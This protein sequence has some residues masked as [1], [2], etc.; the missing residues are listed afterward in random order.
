MCETIVKSG[1]DGEETGFADKGGNAFLRLIKRTY[2]ILRPEIIL[3]HG[4]RPVSCSF[5]LG[6]GKSLYFENTADGT[7]QE[8]SYCA[9]ILF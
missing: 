2:V 4:H 7:C 8:Y 3:R 6:L 9:L 5:I 1:L